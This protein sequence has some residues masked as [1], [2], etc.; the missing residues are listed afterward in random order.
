MSESDEDTIIT[1][2]NNYLQFVKVETLTSLANDIITMGIFVAYI[3]GAT[4]WGVFAFVIYY[5]VV[6]GLSLLFNTWI[7]GVARFRNPYF[8][9]MSYGMSTI[10]K[11]NEQ[12]QE[13]LSKKIKG[14]PL[15]E[16]EGKV[17]QALAMRDVNTQNRE[18]AFNMRLLTNI[19]VSTFCFVAMYGWLD[20]HP[21][22]LHH[23]NMDA[24]SSTALNINVFEFKNVAVSVILFTIMNF[25]ATICFGLRLMDDE[26]DITTENDDERNPNDIFSPMTAYAIVGYIH[27]IILAIFTIISMFALLEW[28]VGLNVITIYVIGGIAFLFYIFYFG[29]FA[30]YSWSLDTASREKGV[31]RA[32]DSTIKFRTIFVHIVL[33]CVYVLLMIIAVSNIDVVN[34]ND[35]TLPRFNP[36]VPEKMH[37]FVDFQMFSTI[38]GPFTI[39]VVYAAFT[40]YLTCKNGSSPYL[41]R[42]MSRATSGKQSRRTSAKEVSRY[43]LVAW[44]Y[45]M[46]VRVIKIIQF[47]VIFA[48]VIINLSTLYGVRWLNHSLWIYAIVLT[49][50]QSIL[51]LVISYIGYTTVSAQSSQYIIDLFSFD[52]AL[53]VPVIVSYTTLQL[54][55]VWHTQS[56]APLDNH[57]ITNTNAAILDQ[58]R[59][60]AAVYPN[61]MSASLYLNLVL[62][63]IAISWVSGTRML[64]YA[65]ESK[66]VVDLKEK[67]QRTDKP[68]RLNARDLNFPPQ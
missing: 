50:V 46:T 4:E 45:P 66:K 39:F 43:N 14:E 58:T 35:G 30:A 37:W 61:L 9:S 29:L 48:V 12:Q 51:M 17:D 36:A 7:W 68:H 25:G 56:L 41:L 33:V 59:H 22:F 49:V 5:T 47:I 11:L 10:N 57:A 55:I 13:L 60:V 6:K 16:I 20:H 18:R 54:A 34:D 62:I 3:I 8:F 53:F 28:N 31:K 23:P 26:E 15:L 1:E 32:M 27:Y 24:P 40:H 44:D 65:P 42:V 52:N 64:Q 21:K 38:A 2:H 19:V 67:V 63:G